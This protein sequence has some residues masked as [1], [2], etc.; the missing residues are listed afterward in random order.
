MVELT[1]P[2]EVRRA[3]SKLPVLDFR[4]AKFALFRDLPSKSTMEKSPEGKRVPKKLVNTQESP[5]PKSEG[6]HPN[7]EEVR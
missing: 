2:G 6:R 3:H 7:K 4:R 1:I 5:L